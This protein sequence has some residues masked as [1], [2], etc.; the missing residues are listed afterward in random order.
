[1]GVKSACLSLKFVTFRKLNVKKFSNIKN[2]LFSILVC[3]VSISANAQHSDNEIR[4]A[5]LG[6]G[7][8]E[9]FL[10]IIE[11]KTANALPH[12]LNSDVVIVS[13]FITIN[14][15]MNT[16]FCIHR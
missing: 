14:N 4:D 2:S 10:K 15:P 16:L 6:V 12:K 8:P 13:V 5:I 7:G 9:K 11:R 1:M 3:F